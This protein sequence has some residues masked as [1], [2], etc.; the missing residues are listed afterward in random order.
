MFVRTPIGPL[1]LL[2]EVSLHRYFGV[3]RALLVFVG[4]GLFAS[5][6]NT[7][8]SMPMAPPESDGFLEGL[9][10]I[11]AILVGVIGL[12]VVQFGYVFPAGS[13]RFS[14]GPLATRTAAMRGGIIVLVYLLTAF[15]MVY[16]I[17]FLVPSVTEST[18]YATGLFVFIIAGGI[19]TGITVLLKLGNLTQRFLLGM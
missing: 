2:R 5:G 10:Y 18:T 15:L 4:L 6:L 16:A 1:S 3:F 12:V 8:A 17:P 11:H 7:V 9:A 14:V 13:G 19:G